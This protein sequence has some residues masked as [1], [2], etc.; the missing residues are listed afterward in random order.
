VDRRLVSSD[1]HALVS[2]ALER[3]GFLAVFAERTGG[4]SEGPFSSLNLGPD[5]GDDP[6]LI[7]ANR[8]RLTEALGLAE[9]AT[10][11]QVHGAKVVEV[12]RAPGIEGLER[13][14]DADA[15][16]TT[17]PSVP[18]AVLTA[19]C[20][21]LALASEDEGRL[22]VVHLGWRGIAAGLVQAA[23]AR[24]SDPLRVSAAIGPSIGPCHYEVGEE[25]LAAVRAGTGGIAVAERIDGSLRLDLGATVQGLLRELGVVEIDRA[26]DCTACEPGRF[27]SHRRDG[28]TGRH[29]LVAVRL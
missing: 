2:P 22:A 8:D 21:P 27:F 5:T 15:L 29:A 23:T 19:D 28:A 12:E 25:V 17:A 13:L 9:L 26:P 7:L 16:T 24:F 6:D 11:R 18:L 3:A 4:R 20:V 14:G 10:V 1:I